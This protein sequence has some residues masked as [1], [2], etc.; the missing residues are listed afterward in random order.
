ME[1]D[2]IK[3]RINK[4]KELIDDGDDC[5]TAHREE[6]SLFYDFIFYISTLKKP[7]SEKAKEVLKSRD[8]DF[9]RWFA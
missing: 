2:E 8:I 1:I 7:I 9:D 6:I 5:Q 3:E 4:I